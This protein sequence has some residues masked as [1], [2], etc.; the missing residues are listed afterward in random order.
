MKTSSR[1]R[2]A[3]LASVVGASLSGC[4]DASRAVGPDET[5]IPMPVALAPVFMEP[6][7]DAPAAP[8]THI[9]LEAT[10]QD[11]G[12]IVGSQVIEV[13]P[14]DA[15]W[16][17]ELTVEVPALTRLDVEIL[18]VLLSGDP[19]AAVEEWSGR[20]GV[21]SLSASTPDRTVNT[22]PVY[23]G[24]PANLDVER[25]EAS[26][27]RALVDGDRVP[28]QYQLQ[29]GGTG[30]RIFLKSLD[31]DVV[32]LDGDVVIGRGVGVGR[33]V[34]EAGP[35]VDTVT[36]DVA[37]FELPNP[38]EIEVVGPSL[39]D[40]STRLL[41]G[42]SDAAGAQAIADGFT[43]LEA[44]IASGSGG[45]ILRALQA[46]RQS[47][48]DYNGGS[49]GAEGPELSL[50]LHSLDVLELTVRGNQGT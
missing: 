6:A 7:T 10:D 26:L 4:V 37:P 50:V 13:N 3:L 31:P 33:I 17:V 36:I 15:T 20:T 35:A 5:T 19:T 49:W 38:D 43:A 44:A 12:A 16:L 30:A 28:L 2:T 41:G 11:T 46:T 24:P 48:A 42:L 27:S 18:L 9:R 21:L 29:G 40:S 1:I 23:R 34:A 22:L 39:D 45:D 25:V 47:V 14:D 8:V 32:Q